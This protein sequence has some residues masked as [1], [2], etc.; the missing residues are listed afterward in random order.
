MGTTSRFRVEPVDLS[1]TED[2]DA[3]FATYWESRKNP[4]QFIGIL[5]HP[6]IGE[7]GHREMESYNA[8]K[9]GYL[10]SARKTPNQRW[11]KIVDCDVPGAARIIGGGVFTIVPA[12]EGIDFSPISDR[13]IQQNLPDIKRPGL[14]YPFGSERNILMRQLFSQLWSLRPRIMRGRPHICK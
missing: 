3:L 5:S 12:A 4:L 1:R 8:A 13:S 2:W 10:E 6:W 14:N 9:E 11:L 7:G